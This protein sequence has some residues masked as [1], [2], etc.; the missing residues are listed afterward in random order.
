MMSENDSMEEESVEI[1]HM[2]D[3]AKAAVR[4]MEAMIIPFGEDDNKDSE[5]AR[6]QRMSRRGCMK[7][8]PLKIKFVLERMEEL[9]NTDK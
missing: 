3:V 9:C 4:E 7:A 5:E 6:K 2:N 1:P 8:N